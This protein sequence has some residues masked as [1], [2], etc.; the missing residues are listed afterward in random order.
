MHTPH[1]AHSGQRV[2]CWI[3]ARARAR[4]SQGY[5]KSDKAHGK[6]TLTYAQGDKYIG[7]WYG[8]KKH[9]EG[10]LQYVARSL[11]CAHARVPCVRRGLT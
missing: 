6:G 3:A 8:G 5:W 1:A 4:T 2:T 11:A 7:D 10:E 9:G